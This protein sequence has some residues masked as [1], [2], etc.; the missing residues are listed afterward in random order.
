MSLP[1]KFFKERY[2]KFLESAHKEAHSFLW[3]PMA[4]WIALKNTENLANPPTRVLMYRNFREIYPPEMPQPK[5]QRFLFFD[6]R[7][8][9]EKLKQAVGS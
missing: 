2:R 4:Q 9:Q 3:P 6:Y 5:P 1:E 7:V 8:N